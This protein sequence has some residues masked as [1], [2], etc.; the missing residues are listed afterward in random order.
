MKRYIL[1]IV[2]CLSLSSF[3]ISDDLDG[4]WEVSPV[5]SIRHDNLDDGVAVSDAIGLRMSLGGSKFTGFDTDGTDYRIFMGWGLGKLGICHDGSGDPEYTFGTTY[6]V[7][8]N[9]SMDLDYVFGEDDNNLRLA[10]QIHF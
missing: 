1:S 9:V 3:L 4:Y 8:D 6:E 7:L 5:L 10:I 2:L